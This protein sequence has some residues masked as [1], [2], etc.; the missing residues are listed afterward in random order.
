MSLGSFS[1]RWCLELRIKTRFKSG[2]FKL[3]ANTVITSALYYKWRCYGPLYGRFTM[4]YRNRNVIVGQFSR[5]LP[6]V[7]SLWY[8]C[9]FLSSVCVICPIRIL[10]LLS[11][12]SS[13]VDAFFHFSHRNKIRSLGAPH[14]YFQTLLAPK[15]SV[16]NQDSLLIASPQLGFILIT[17]PR[18]VFLMSAGINFHAPVV[19]SRVEKWRLV[20]YGWIEKRLS[21]MGMVTGIENQ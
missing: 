17:I 4:K 10:T 9:A 12:I 6:W 1:A 13:Q 14:L 3:W 21:Y 20:G 5:C 15:C 11:Q 8:Q 16:N 18:P 19:W 7:A 2:Q